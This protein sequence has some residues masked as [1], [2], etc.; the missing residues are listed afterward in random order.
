M[1]AKHR[2]TYEIRRNAEE[3]AQ[4]LY[5]FRNWLGSGEWT[6][7]INTDGATVRRLRSD[8]KLNSLFFRSFLG[9]HKQIEFCCFRSCTDEVIT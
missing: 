2:Q 6:L 9:K 7:D 8:I 4:N 1:F 3:N 5:I